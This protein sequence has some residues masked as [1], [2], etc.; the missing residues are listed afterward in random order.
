[1]EI[2]AVE[3]QDKLIQTMYEV[4]L[5][6]IPYAR[7]NWK[8]MGHS[9]YIIREDG[10]VNVY[11]TGSAIQ[12]MD[13]LGTARNDLDFMVE[14]KEHVF[15]VLSKY[16]LNTLHHGKI[17]FHLDTPHRTYSGF[18][19][20][21][22][23]PNYEKVL[24]E[25]FRDLSIGSHLKPF[26]LDKD[27]LSNTFIK[28]LYSQFH[29]LDSNERKVDNEHT[30]AAF[31]A[32]M[33]DESNDPLDR[34][35]VLC[36]ICESWPDN[37]K[38]EY[39]VRPRPSGWP[40]SDLIS[41]VLETPVHVIPAGHP[42]SS[43]RHLEWRLSCSFAETELLQSLSPE[44]HAVFILAKC[45]ISRQ[46]DAFYKDSPKPPHAI[47]TFHIKNLFLWECEK[48]NNWRKESI[49]SNVQDFI[50]RFVASLEKMELQHYFIPERNLLGHLSQLYVLAFASFLQKS[51][52]THITCE[53]A[54]HTLGMDLVVEQLYLPNKRKRIEQILFQRN[55][56]IV[57]DSSGETSLNVI[58]EEW[59]QDSWLASAKSIMNVLCKKDNNL[60][61][62][63]QRSTGAANTYFNKIVSK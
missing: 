1:M 57:E 23:M 56:D 33:T 3:I 54:Y 27:Y 60:F 5:T 50:K 31:T 28:G 46:L 42:H 19:R 6:T 4:W 38:H 16:D 2:M 35:Y 17:P 40:S 25:L 41:K 9:Q 47:S 55:C 29:E 8:I 26:L 53:V 48:R 37:I 7:E 10:M 21:K 11:I 24:D 61:K 49:M 52:S 59:L 12:L 58:S 36:F 44:H 51:S 22:L 43:T 34:D 20:L 18:Y 62:D 39:K 45:L 63:L 32:S 14:V 30:S 13:Y 15:G